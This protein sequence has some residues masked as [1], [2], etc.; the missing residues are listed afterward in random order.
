MPHWSSSLASGVKTPMSGRKD[1][2]HETRTP[3]VEVDDHRKQVRHDSDA[4]AARQ[5]PQACVVADGPSETC[6]HCGTMIRA[7]ALIFA[8]LASN[9]QQ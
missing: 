7:T 4:M 9:L 2:C 6:R 5:S 3:L 1:Q 8:L